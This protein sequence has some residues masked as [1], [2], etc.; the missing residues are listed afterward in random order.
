VVWG[1]TVRIVRQGLQRKE[2]VLTNVR[3]NLSEIDKL[4]SAGKI[5]NPLPRQVRER[6]LLLDA[7]RQ[8]DK[9]LVKRKSG[10]TT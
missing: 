5:E 9:F 4:H 2:K 3:S 10:V 7:Y 8:I 1:R 6:S